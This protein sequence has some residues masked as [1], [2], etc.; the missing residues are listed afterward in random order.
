MPPWTWNAFYRATSTQD[1]PWHSGSAEPELMDLV[2]YGRLKPCRALDVGCGQGT[3]AVFLALARFKVSAI[4]I[5]PRALAR[6]KKLA[7]LL[8]AKV[9]F[10]LGSALSLPFRAREFAFVTDRGCFHSLGEEERPQW[11]AEIARVLRPGGTLLLRTFSDKANRQAGPHCFARKELLDAV[12]GPFRVTSLKM[13]P[14]LGNGGPPME[15]LWALVAT[16]VTSFQ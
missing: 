5:A 16:R 3:E 7:K 11:V 6:A 9:D 2:R 13:Y 8:G 1:L 10:R 12:K 14:A 15:P 4:D